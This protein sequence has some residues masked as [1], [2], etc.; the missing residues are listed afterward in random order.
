IWLLMK[1][2][3]HYGHKDFVLCLGHQ[4]EYIKNFFLNFNE[5]LTNDFVLTEGGAD[6]KLMNQDIRDWRIT[7]TDTGLQTN[8]GGRLRAARRFVQHEEVF[9]ANYTDGLSNVHLDRMI[10]EFLT[11]GA[12]AG[13]LSVQPNVSFHIV[14]ADAEG[15]VK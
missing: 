9:L 13:F 3:A 5:C 14:Q 10:D 15:R 1:Y 7:F 12:V 2:Y 4:A 6:L 11:T 8:I